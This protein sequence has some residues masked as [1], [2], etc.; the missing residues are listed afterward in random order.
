MI[1]KWNPQVSRASVSKLDLDDISEGQG[2]GGDGQ[3]LAVVPANEGVLGH[4]VLEAFHDLG[5]LGLLVVGEDA[6]DSDDGGE[7]DSEVEV[8]I[9]RLF[10]G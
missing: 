2:V 6:G 5:G 4:E 10:V 3:L 1:K 9:R 8:V 7:D